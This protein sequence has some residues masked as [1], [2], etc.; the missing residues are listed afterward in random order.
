VIHPPP[1]EFA[2]QRSVRGAPE[3]VSIAERSLQRS[4]AGRRAALRY[5][6]GRPRAPRADDRNRG[7]ALAWHRRPA[8]APR[9][10]RD[11]A[12]RAGRSTK[13]VVRDQRRGRT[14]VGD[15]ERQGQRPND[16]QQRHARRAPSRGSTSRFHRVNRL[17]NANGFHREQARDRVA[18]VE[19]V[20]ALGARFR[21]TTW[22]R[23]VAQSARS[24]QVCDEASVIA[25]VRRRSRALRHTASMPCAKPPSAHG[26]RPLVCA[27]Y[28]PRAQLIGRLRL[29]ADEHTC[30][31]NNPRA[32]RA[33]SDPSTRPPDASA[34]Q[35]PQPAVE[36]NRLDR[37][38]RGRILTGEPHTAPDC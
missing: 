4:D 1:D 32:G 14:H 3:P 17:Q 16:G 21:L 37:R 22:C 2:G 8:R 5:H 6:E 27:A 18:R 34:I 38:W 36:R 31:R 25:L 12:T 30:W 35:G 28:V 20:L 23:L 7:K 13:A 11:R 33:R 24:S 19:L 29:L 9:R 10:Q 26:T 15:C